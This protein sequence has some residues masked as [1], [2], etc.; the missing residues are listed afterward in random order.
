MPDE[1]VNIAD[2]Q[3]RLALGVA[4]ALEDAELLGWAAYALALVHRAYFSHSDAVDAAVEEALR[5]L[6]PEQALEK[7]ASAMKKAVAL[8]G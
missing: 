3:P 6:P 4:R 5:K 1:R 2:R 8:L 7:V